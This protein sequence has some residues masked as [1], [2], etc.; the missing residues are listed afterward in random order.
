MSDIQTANGPP[1]IKP[2]ASRNYKGGKGR[3][4]GY[5]PVKYV[6]INSMIEEFQKTLGC[7]FQ[8]AWAELMLEARDKYASGDDTKTYPR[9]M[10]NALF[11]FVENP[12]NQPD[13]TKA[14]LDG[15][16][17]DELAKQAQI[18]A[19]KVLEAA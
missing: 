7:S 10:E 15:L 5:S 18:L 16:T 13:D 2:K 14:E 4:K 19:K 3:A 8:E 6:T 12:R 11:K 17:D 9:M 1:A